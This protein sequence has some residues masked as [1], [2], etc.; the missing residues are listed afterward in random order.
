ML[1]RTGDDATQ[2]GM[3]ASE[4]CSVEKTFKIGDCF[5]RCPKCESLC[6]W[7]NVDVVVPPDGFETIEHQAA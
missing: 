1:M 7:E 3:Y 6:E 2:F 4:C 5:S